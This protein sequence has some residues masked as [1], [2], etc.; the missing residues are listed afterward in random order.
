MFLGE[1]TDAL[2]LGNYF[3]KISGKYVSL[4]AKVTDSGNRIKI[5]VGD[6]VLMHYY[7]MY[8]FPGSKHA[9]S[10]NI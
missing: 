3:F 6:P 2:I 7:I 8:C 10:G 5:Y 9:I 4:E 1:A